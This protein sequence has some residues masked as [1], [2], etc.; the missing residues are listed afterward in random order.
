MMKKCYFDDYQEQ[1]LVDTVARNQSLNTL[2]LYGKRSLYG[3]HFTQLPGDATRKRTLV[4]FETNVSVQSG[5]L[6]AG[7]LPTAVRNKQRLHRAVRSQSLNASSCSWSIEKDDAE[8]FELFA[9]SGIL[10]DIYVDA[11]RGRQRVRL[12]TFGEP[13]PMVRGTTL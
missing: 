9:V 12:L 10:K 5:T 7:L 2:I 4:R 3:I 1:C 8:C 6:W 13:G 11:P